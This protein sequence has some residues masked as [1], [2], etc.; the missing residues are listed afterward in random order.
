MKSRKALLSLLKVYPGNLFTWAV[1]GLLVFK[2]RWWGLLGFYAF[3]VIFAASY[4]I[5]VEEG[6]AKFF[7]KFSLGKDD[8]LVQWCCRPSLHVWEKITVEEPRTLGAKLFLESGSFGVRQLFRVGN[9]SCSFCNKK[10]NFVSFPSDERPCLDGHVNWR[11]W[12]VMSKGF[13]EM[14]REEQESAH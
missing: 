13:Y 9:G 11:S 6:R 12:T 14:Y 7:P 5:L 1:L 3:M 2:F 8:W 4:V 10:E